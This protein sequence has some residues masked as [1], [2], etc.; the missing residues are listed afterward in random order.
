M[1]TIRIS[2]IFDICDLRSGQ[3]SGSSM[4]MNGGNFQND[5]NCPIFSGLRWDRPSLKTPVQIFTFDLWE[6]IWGHDY[7]IRGH[8]SILS[9]SGDWE[10]METWNW[11]QS[12]R[13][14]IAD[15]MICIMT[16]LGHFVTL[17]WPWPGVKF[18]IDALRSYYISLEP[19]WREEL[20]GDRLDS[21]A[22]LDKNL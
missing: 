15:R 12:I 7:V 18:Q 4:L 16:Y 14:V 17:T 22:F 20:D 3:F 8:N 19:A 1:A 10:E 6:V 5:Q 9:I 2:R 11:H 13:L 21:L